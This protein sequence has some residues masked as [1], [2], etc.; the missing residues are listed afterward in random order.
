MD[1]IKDIFS[2]FIDKKKVIKGF[3]SKIQHSIFFD[4]LKE[5][6]EKYLRKI[7]NEPFIKFP[8][9][10][11]EIKRYF[12]L[13]VINVLQPYENTEHFLYQLSKSKHLF[14]WFKNTSKCL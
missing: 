11:F 14:H 12:R 2:D 8:S 6:H 3:T 4:K 10:N 7:A 13:Q 1:I 9:R 5:S